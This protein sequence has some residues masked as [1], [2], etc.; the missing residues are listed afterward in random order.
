MMT[1]DEL[2]AKY[3]RLLRPTFHF[4]CHEGWL[5]ILDAYFAVVDHVMPQGAVYQIG[6]IKETLGTLRLYDSS[7]GETWASVKAGTAAPRLADAPSQHTREY[8]LG[9]ASCR[10]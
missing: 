6:Q 2:R 4:M 7:Y 3:P 1:F 8:Q 5:G 10:E 9:R